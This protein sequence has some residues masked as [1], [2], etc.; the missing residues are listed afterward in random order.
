MSN[1]N[2]LQMAMEWVAEH[3]DTTAEDF[4]AIFQINRTKAEQ[5]VTELE[6]AH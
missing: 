6:K 5:L 3:G 4:M 2:L 1:E